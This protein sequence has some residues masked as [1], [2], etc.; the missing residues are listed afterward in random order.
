MRLLDGHQDRGTGSGQAVVMSLHWLFVDTGWRLLVKRIAGGSAHGRS[1][2][3]ER[4]AASG[5][6]EGPRV[7]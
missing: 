7:S 6:R 5:R 2:T 3:S 1:A 4:Y